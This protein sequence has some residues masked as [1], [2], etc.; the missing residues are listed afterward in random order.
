MT[1]V[2][3]VEA[4]RQWNAEN[5]ALKDMRLWGTQILW[6]GRIGKIAMFVSGLVLVL[7]IIGPERMRRVTE[8]PGASA[9]R[10]MAQFHRKNTSGE[11]PVE[12]RSGYGRFAGF[13]IA[14]SVVAVLLLA[15]SVIQ[16]PLLQERPGLQVLL[17]VLFL[18]AVYFT[19]VLVFIAG[20]LVVEWLFDHERLVQVIRIV[21]LV[22]FLGGFHFDLLAS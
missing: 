12:G 8:R 3:L 1:A 22:L 7:D 4:W 9:R 17:I 6:W 19:G 2:D 14:L 10:L 20:P 21:S 18:P 13:V 16:N 11:E 15:V 5:P